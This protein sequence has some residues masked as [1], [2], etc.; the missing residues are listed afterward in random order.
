[1]DND[2]LGAV[3]DAHTE[4]GE[5]VQEPGGAADPEGT[6]EPGTPGEGAVAAGSEG[7][8]EERPSE[9]SGQ[10]GP[11]A[12]AAAAGEGAGEGASPGAA[13]DTAAELASLKAALA[14]RDQQLQALSEIQQFQRALDADPQLAQAV[15]SA[16]ADY[17]RGR[18]SGQSSAP[19]SPSGAPEVR[20]LEPP[21]RGWTEEEAALAEYANSLAQ[22]NQAVLARLAQIEQITGTQLQ[23]QFTARVEELSSQTA[24]RFKDVT[25]EDPSA[26]EASLKRTLAAAGQRGA[27]LKDVAERELR[28]HA[29]GKMKPAAQPGH[30]TKRLEQ[31]MQGA[32]RTSGGAAAAPA[33]PGAPAER[34]TIRQEARKTIVDSVKGFL[35]RASA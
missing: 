6:T 7:A 21:E 31:K 9:E 13:G 2:L 11:A 15:T 3:R 17:A 4:I 5:T 23:T 8:S 12:P 14:E 35:T 28:Y 1:M 19:P 10:G 34:P 26:F 18:G 33:A 20:L 22:Q 29:F 27:D 16:V 32:I 30:E 24:A 25:G